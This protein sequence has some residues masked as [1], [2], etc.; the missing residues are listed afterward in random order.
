MGTYSDVGGTGG[1]AASCGLQAGAAREGSQTLGTGAALQ[2]TVQKREVM[3]TSP[4]NSSFVVK[5]EERF[6]RVPQM[7]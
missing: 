7:R 5:H 3:L 6:P 2:D 4:I 1:G